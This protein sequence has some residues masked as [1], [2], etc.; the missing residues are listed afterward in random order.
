MTI[1]VN[2]WCFVIHFHCLSFWILVWRTHADL[3]STV[4]IFLQACQVHWEVSRCYSSSLLLFFGFCLISFYSFNLC[5]NP[6]P[7]HP[8]FPTF[9]SE[10]YNITDKYSLL[11]PM[12]LSELSFTLSVPFLVLQDFSS[13]TN[14]LALAMI[15]LVADGDKQM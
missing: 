9:P 3:A 5:W 12:S 8:Y 7:F 13:L 2:C 14:S 11:L 10:S 15:L 4:L 6:P 1:L